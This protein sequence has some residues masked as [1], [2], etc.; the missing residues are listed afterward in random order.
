MGWHKSILP[1]GRSLVCFYLNLSYNNFTLCT[2]GYVSSIRWHVSPCKIIRLKYP[3]KSLEMFALAIEVRPK[4]VLQD[5]RQ[6]ST[7]WL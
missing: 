3:V 4:K 2:A 1:K 5:P 7:A 6:N